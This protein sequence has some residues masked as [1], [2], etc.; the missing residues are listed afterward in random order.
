VIS[1]LRQRTLFAGGH[2]WG[3]GS[4]A[5][6]HA[7][8]RHRLVADNM[9]YSSVSLLNYGRW[10]IVRWLFFVPITRPVASYRELYS[11]APV[12][13]AGIDR[14]AARGLAV[15]PIT[16]VSYRSARTGS[17]FIQHARGGWRYGR[18]AALSSGVYHGGTPLLRKGFPRSSIGTLSALHHSNIDGTGVHFFF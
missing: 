18:Q 17:R 3:A 10:L 12:A 15:L 14:R 2:S 1:P 13:V 9:F 8:R 6:G 16:A 5:G 4:A 7:Y 11:I